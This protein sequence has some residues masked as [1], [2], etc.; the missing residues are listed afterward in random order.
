MLEMA[1]KI[2]KSLLFCFPLEQHMQW[3]GQSRGQGK[4]AAD[5]MDHIGD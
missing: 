5:G 1:L 2:S 4:V 3:G